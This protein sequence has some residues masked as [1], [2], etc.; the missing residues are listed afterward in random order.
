MSAMQKYLKASSFPATLPLFQF[1]NGQYL[2]PG[3][4]KRIMQVTRSELELQQQQQQQQVL[5]IDS[6]KPLAG[7]LVTATLG[8]SGLQAPKLSEE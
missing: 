1:Q 3:M 8:T 7:G 2:G 4:I 6:F 5:P